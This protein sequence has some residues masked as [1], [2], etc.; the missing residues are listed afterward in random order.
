MPTAIATDGGRI[1]GYLMPYH[2]GRSL[3]GYL[4]DPSV[5]AS[6]KLAAFVQLAGVLKRL[7]PGV[8][9]GDLHGDNVIVDGSGRIH[10][11][12]LDGFSV[13][14][15][16]LLTCPLSSL[17]SSWEPLRL[18][19]YRGPGGAFRVSRDSDIFCYFR[20]LLMWIMGGID[21]TTYTVGELFRYL[22]YLESAGFSEE[23]LRMLRR[24]FRPGANRI[25]PRAIAGIDAA[26]AEEYGYGV[27]LRKTGQL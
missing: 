21:F 7:P 4:E 26:A 14:P 9:V 18:R 12:D 17:A 10:L 3:Y 1:V 22:D 5:D 24:L 25:D 2:P 15:R 8:F 19:K 23:T 11:I 6:A 20:L 27:Y 13:R 16:Y